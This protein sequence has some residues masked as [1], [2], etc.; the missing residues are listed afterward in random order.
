M[1]LGL[2]VDV[3]DRDEAVALPRRGRPRARAGRRGSQTT[4][5]MPSSVTRARP[6][7]HEL[8]DR[9][10]RRRARASSR[11]R[12]RGPGRSTSTASSEPTFAAPAAQAGLVRRGAQ[13]GAALLLDRARNAC[14]RPP[15]SCPGRGEYGKTCTFVIPARATTSSV[16]SNA[17]S[18][19]PGKPTITSVVR[20]K[21][22]S[23][24]TPAQVRRRPCSAGP[25]RA[26]RRRRPTGAARAGARDDGRRL[27]QRRDELV[28]DVVD[29]D[30]GQAQP[31]EARASRRPRG[32]GARA[33][34]RRRGRGSSRG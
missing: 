19:S 9:R 28:V 6:G 27:A 7:A 22:V 29:L 23:G 21:S 2:R 4:P 1:R 32:R 24:P 8:A 12:S 13:P 17:A 20:L 3:A 30:R 25:S 16:R 11:R 26:G 15:S 18:S 34:S 10:V 5:T 33:G 14:P 31:R